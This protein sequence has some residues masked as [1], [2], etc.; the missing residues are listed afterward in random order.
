MTTV[1]LYSDPKSALSAPNNTGNGDYIWQLR[2]SCGFV[3]GGVDTA[4]QAITGFSPLDEWVMKPFVG[5]WNAYE[6][7]A[8]VWRQ[9]GKAAEL[10]GDALEELPRQAEGSWNGEAFDAWAAAQQKVSGIVD[11]LPGACEA[12]AEF[13]TALIEF[14]LAILQFILEILNWIAE[15]VIRILA[16]QFVPVIGQ[17]AGAAEATILCGRV[18]IQSAKVIAQLQKFTSLINKVLTIMGVIQQVY[19]ML[20]PVLQALQKAQ[21]AADAAV[22]ASQTASAAGT[23]ATS[24]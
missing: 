9:A 10:V 20:I 12:M 19:T 15:T 4:V 6:N 1:T 5:D 7:A 18:T 16:E 24:P 23:A 3:I 8:D 2:L 22:S 14:G 11:A 13:T 17:I 21:Q